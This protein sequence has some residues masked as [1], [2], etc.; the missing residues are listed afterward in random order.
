MKLHIPVLSALIGFLL[1]I[2]PMGMAAALENS[3]RMDTR[4]FGEKF[5]S[6]R[7]NSGFPGWGPG[8]LYGIR[9]A[10]RGR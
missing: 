3:M 6:G 5:Q 2:F 7:Q 1:T 8:R 9:S 10:Y 4:G